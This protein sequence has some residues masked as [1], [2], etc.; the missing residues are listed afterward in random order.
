MRNFERNLLTEWRRLRL[1]VSDASV[2]VAVSGGA[3]SMSLALALHELTLQKKLENRTVLA[4]FN[5]NLRGDES[6]ADEDF[7]R[8][9]A[10]AHGIE[11]A[12]GHA[13]PMGKG[14]LEQNARNAR[15]G[16]LEKTAH[17]VKA[18][19]VLTAHTVDDQ[20]E[21]FLMNLIRGAGPTGLSAMPCIREFGNSSGFDVFPEDKP[22]QSG[23]V[24]L[25]RPMLSWAHRVDAENYCHELGQGF[26]YDSMNDDLGFMRVRVRKLLM[27]MLR[28]FNPNISEAIARAADI[29]RFE[30]GTREE[31][32]AE[33]SWESDTLKVSELKPLT[34]ERLLGGLR[35]WLGHRRGDLRGVSLEHI[36]SI[37]DLA[38]STKS[39]RV[40]EIPGKCR[41]VKTKGLLV[42][43]K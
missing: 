9:F 14:N 32:A 1:P 31:A 22:I 5:H 30:L 35:M 41:V 38:L 39:G 23:Q 10:E 19:V 33:P 3:D 12:V 26:Q 7:V 8:H 42:F 43:E 34:R 15:Y 18:E 36:E 17:S 6:R 16:F 28:E 40:A 25:V 11:L 37:A 27:P 21:T 13:G 4:H 2:I 29:I 20:A 24:Y